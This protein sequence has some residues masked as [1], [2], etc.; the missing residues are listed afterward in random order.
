M[1]GDAHIYEAKYTNKHIN[2][3]ERE[4]ERERERINGKRRHSRKY[5]HQPQ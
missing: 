4:R 3:Y 5:P 1:P 2:T